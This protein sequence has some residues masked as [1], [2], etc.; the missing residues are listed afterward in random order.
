MW[1]FYLWLSV[2][3]SERRRLLILFLTPT[4][5]VLLSETIIADRKGEGQSETLQFWQAK[6]DSMNRQHEMLRREKL[7][8]FEQTGAFLADTATVSTWLA[9]GL[10]I[11][12]ANRI[13]NYISAGGSISDVEDLRRLHIGDSL[14]QERVGPMLIR[15]ER[16]SKG[17]Y[18]RSIKLGSPFMVN[19]NQPDSSKLIAAG[20]PEEVVRR[21]CKYVGA[22][23]ELRTL[24]DLKDIYGMK[25]EWVD[26]W[27]DSLIF[28]IQRE[29]STIDINTFSLDSFMVD[30]GWAQWQID[31]VTHYRTRLGGFHRVDQLFEVGIDSG[32]VEQMAIL[33]VVNGGIM[34]MSFNEMA[35]TDLAKHPYV[36]WEMAKAV[37]YYRTRV[38]PI[39]SLTDLVGMEGWNEESVERLQVYFKR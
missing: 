11:S 19:I 15:T 6:V 12:E 8:S 39:E 20:W 26:Q 2:K 23:G 24:S 33:A 4:L 29:W 7:I 32:R 36:T 25:D 18:D 13:Y 21:W 17:T 14:W 28:P 37:E 3:R 10:N 35:W 34:K 27:K 5:I 16:T 38:R 22:G 31:K 1:R 30:R 9:S